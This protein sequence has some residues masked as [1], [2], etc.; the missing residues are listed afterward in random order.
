MTLT[1]VAS[2]QGDIHILRL[3]TPHPQNPLSLKENKAEQLYS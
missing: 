1:K 3:K 2:A